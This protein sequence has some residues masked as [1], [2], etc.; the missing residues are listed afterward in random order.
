MANHQL[1]SRGKRL[2]GRVERDDERVGGRDD[3]ERPQ[4]GDLCA[5]LCLQGGGQLVRRDVGVSGRT[6]VIEAKG[7]PS[8]RIDTG[9]QVKTAL[10]QVEVRAVEIGEAAI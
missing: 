6:A 5:E 8:V 1:R 2:G 10:I 9:L 3:A 4:A 7:E